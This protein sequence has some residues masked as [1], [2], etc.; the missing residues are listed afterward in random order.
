MKFS[1]GMSR[2][3]FLFFC[4][5]CRDAFSYLWKRVM[6]VRDLGGGGDVLGRVVW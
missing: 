2:R 5:C 4:Q 1:Y 6:R 3:T